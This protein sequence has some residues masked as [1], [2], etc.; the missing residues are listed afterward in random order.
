MNN[1]IQNS[2]QRKHLDSNADKDDVVFHIQNHFG[3]D[4][5]TFSQC[6]FP[7]QRAIEI[8]D[9]LSESIKTASEYINNNNL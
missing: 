7:L 6:Y 5:G 8:R 4:E 3:E 1:E 9:N 2:K